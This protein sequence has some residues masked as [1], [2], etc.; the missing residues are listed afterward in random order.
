[1]HK[2]DAGVRWDISL[3]VGTPPQ[4]LSMLPDTGA[5]DFEVGSTLLPANLT[6]NDPAYNPNVST[7]AHLLHGYTY[8]VK[9]VSGFWSSGVV[10]LDV[11]TI[12]NASWSNV[13]ILA[14]TNAEKAR[15]DSQTGN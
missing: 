12:G 6:G 14:M 5:N 9:Y 3:L 10:Y 2:T 11:V 1:M 13:P 15:N 7:T 4:L 8:F